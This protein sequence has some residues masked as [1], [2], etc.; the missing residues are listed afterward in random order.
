MSTATGWTVTMALIGLS[1]ALLGHAPLAAQ[2]LIGGDWRADVENFAASLVESGLA[3][4]L[5]LAVTAGDWVVH[6][7]GFGL[8]DAASGRGVSPDTPFYIASTTKSLTALAAVLAAERGELDLNAPMV[9][10]LPDAVLPDG[11]PRES[12]LV[13]DLI[14]L[15]HGL[16][17]NGPVVVRTAFTGDFTREELLD[18]LR[19]HPPTG[20]AGHFE[21]NNLGF[22]L[23]GLVLES[24]YGTGWKEIV[25]REVTE[26][27]GMKDTHARLSAYGPDRVAM[28]HDVDPLGAFRRIDLAKEDRNLHAAG[29]HFATAGDLARYLAVH[30][31]GGA[32]EGALV[33]PPGPVLATH[34]ERVAQDRQFGPFHRH[35]WGYG[36]DL[37]TYG[38]ET[39]IHRFGGFSGYRSHVSFMPERGLGVVVLTNGSGPAGPAADLMAT[40]IYDRLLERPDLEATYASRIADLAGQA[41]ASRRTMAQHLEERSRRLA[42][43][44]HPLEAYAGTYES[45]TLGRMTVRLVAGGV[46]MRMGV[47][48]S[49]AEV[50]D[51]AE[52][53]LRVEVGGSG[54]V[55]RFDF[56]EGG[57]PARAVQMGADEFRRIDGMGTR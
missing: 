48:R 26:P 8:A 33:L 27:I 53:R 30:L 19:H 20:N 17:G 1:G 28:P 32:V 13:R 54:V 38:E 16:S 47:V 45:P 21:Y 25:A 41:E 39:L 18:L 43:L 11:V 3:P 6:E 24:V 29:G 23:L 57:G 51:A 34:V 44:P 49:R 55:L 35:G 37:G 46:E 7:A 12:V 42:P 56:A 14:S 52:S 36:W 5:A 9:R 2:A 31:T 50:F 15:T 40:Y 4:G 22:N 10:Y